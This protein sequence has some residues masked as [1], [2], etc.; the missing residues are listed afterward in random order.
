MAENG[1]TTPP[2][3]NSTFAIEGGAGPAF[4][5]YTYVSIKCSEQGT[6][7]TTKVM[8][9]PGFAPVSVL[10]NTAGVSAT[11]GD[12]DPKTKVYKSITVGKCAVGTEIIVLGKII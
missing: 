6:A 1:Q 9:I 12:Q 2:A 5:G 10:P 7:S 8:F 3:T 11:L 4:V